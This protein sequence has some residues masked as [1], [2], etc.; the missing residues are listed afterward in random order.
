[1]SCLLD[2]IAWDYYIGVKLEFRLGAYYIY[3]GPQSVGRMYFECLLK[4]YGILICA[5]RSVHN[6]IMS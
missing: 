5:V 3:M 6:I 1:M 2:Y 4:Y